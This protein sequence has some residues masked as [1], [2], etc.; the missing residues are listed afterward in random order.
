MC[1]VQ[2]HD[3]ESLRQQSDINTGESIE[4]RGAPNPRISFGGFRRF[5]Y[6]GIPLF[7][8]EIMTRTAMPRLFLGTNRPEA[9]P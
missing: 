3:M 5:Y 7:K 2:I 6:D 8:L 9:C 1:K 4:K